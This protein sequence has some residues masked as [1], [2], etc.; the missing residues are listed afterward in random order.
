MMLQNFKNALLCAAI[1]STG[2]GV[3]M[4]GATQ[5]LSVDQLKT[6]VAPNLAIGV[7][8]GGNNFVVLGCGT[9]APTHGD[10]SMSAD[11]TASVFAVSASASSAVFGDTVLEYGWEFYVTLKN[12]ESVPATISEIGI[13]YYRP[14]M[15]SPILLTR[16]VFD[17]IT[18]SPGETYALTIS[19]H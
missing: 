19:I 1:G 14:D 8:Q 13:A 5:N 3:D 4:N 18:L 7:T 2:I 15:N 10:Y 6:L 12:H 11:C 17:P 16:D 9:V